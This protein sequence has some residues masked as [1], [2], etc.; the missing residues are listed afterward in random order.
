MFKPLAVAALLLASPAWAQGR[1]PQP[2]LTHL[3]VPAA[4]LL[5]VD[6]T[7]RSDVST[8]VVTTDIGT[9]ENGVWTWNFGAKGFEG[10]QGPYLHRHRCPGLGAA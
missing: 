9:F 2:P 6:I 4:N 5:T 8:G 3:G 1:R 10:T 7:T